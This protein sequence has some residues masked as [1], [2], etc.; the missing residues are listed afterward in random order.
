MTNEDFYPKNLRNLVKEGAG[1]DQNRCRRKLKIKPSKKIFQTETDTGDDNESELQEGENGKK[2]N[3][4]HIVGF[5][6][7]GIFVVGAL[8]VGAYFTL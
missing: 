6:L 2:T 5:S 8:A 1:R 4:G 7:L 3:L